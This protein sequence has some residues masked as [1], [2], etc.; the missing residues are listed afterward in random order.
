[1]I[2]CS[3]AK[4]EQSNKLVLSKAQRNTGCFLLVFQLGE[5]NKT[6]AQKKKK[7]QPVEVVVVTVEVTLTV[8]EAG[9]ASAVPAPRNYDNPCLPSPLEMDPPSALIRKMQL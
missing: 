2:Q 7:Q 5:K 3:L 4:H 8:Q 9:T 1:M 6:H